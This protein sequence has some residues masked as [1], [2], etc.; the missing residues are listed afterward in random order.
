MIMIGS[1]TFW[2]AFWQ[3]LGA[4]ASLYARLP[5]YYVEVVPAPSPRSR[6]EG[7]SKAKAKRLDG[8]ELTA[9]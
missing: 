2:G 9:A 1:S 4:P 8:T 7:A 5:V 3:G 6:N